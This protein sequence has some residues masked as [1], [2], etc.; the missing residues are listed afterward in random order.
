MSPSIHFMSEVRKSCGQT[1]DK[2]CH[3]VLS[4]QKLFENNGRLIHAQS[5]VQKFH[6]C[7]EDS[8]GSTIN[9]LAGAGT[10]CQFS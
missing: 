10:W 4:N 1:T 5:S 2:A 3:L 7:L 6:Y 9:H 8:K